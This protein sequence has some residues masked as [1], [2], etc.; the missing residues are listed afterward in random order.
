MI[1][2]LLHIWFKSYCLY[3]N[4]KNQQYTYDYYL[5]NLRNQYPNNQ[6]YKA[7]V[8]NLAWYCKK[9]EDNDWS[10]KFGKYIIIFSRVN[11]KSLSI[12]NWSDRKNRMRFQKVLGSSINKERVD[13][14]RSCN[15]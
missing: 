6:L 12:M 3:K 15:E 2:C 5:Y 13:E 14:R 11:P 10:F 1:K 4:F 8:Q 7:S 9:Q